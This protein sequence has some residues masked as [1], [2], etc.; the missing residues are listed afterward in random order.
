MILKSLHIE[1]FKGV[2]DKTYEFGKTTRISGM[3][4]RGKT[5]IGA[6]W[7]WLIS[8]K[9]Y[10]LVSNP[11]IR[12]DNVEDCIPTVTANVGVDEKEITLS[13]MQKRKVGKP[14]KNGVS[15]I[16]IT[17][18][19]EI[20]SVPKTERDFKAY[21]EELGFEFDKFLI[22]SHPNVFT[23][24]LSLKK[25]QDEMR[26]SLFAMASAKTDL[27]IAQ[28]NK[29]TADVAKLLESYKFE[30]IEAMNNASKKKA[31]DQLDAIPNQIIGL[32]SAKV[33]VDVAEQELA[34]A[35]LARRIAECDKKIAGADHSLDELRDKE[36]RLQLDISG[37]T[38]TMN[39]E[40]SNRRYEIDADL[41]GCEDELKHLEQTISLK[42]NQ[43]VG[44]EKAITDADAER[45]KI[46][47]KYN[48]EYAKAF[49]EAPYLFDESKWVFDENSTVCSLCGQK[50]PED[51]IEQLKADFESRKEKAKADAEEKLKAK[52]FKFDTDKKVE[53]NRLNTIGTEKK[54]LITEL[55]KKNA[56]L[57]TEIDAL[58]KQEQDAIA[59]KEE[60]SKQLSE[61][62]SEADYTQNEDYVKLKAERDKVLADIEKLESD[63]ADKVVTDLKVE[64]A[65]LQSQ[66]DEVNSIIAQA[67]NNV[68]I[69]EQIAEKRQDQRKYEQAKADA[70]KILYQLKEVSK[71]KNGLL[72]EEI[73]QHFG[74][75]RWKLFDFQKNGEYKEVCIPTVLDEETGIYKVFG[76]TTNTGR[77]I[78]AKIDI[79]NS[80]QKFF[81]MYV[82]IFLDG[83]ESINDEYVPAVDTQLILLTVTEDKQLKVEGV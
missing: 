7:Y 53:L 39:R 60:L 30:E 41:C 8:D 69:D 45:K 78:E 79:C 72:V 28:M 12:P 63:G 29:E 3:N 56:D 23:K 21:L 80:F 81:N 22:C 14:D 26:K 17:N 5:T 20:N 27:E 77:E 25:K 38:Q 55:T 19:Y 67:A 50:L 83:A 65:D 9:N 48:A 34:K 74:I 71:R 32:E 6:A 43:I 10:E 15:K 33:D 76:D 11:N 18:T 58:K 59:K 40:L 57:N 61:I 24:D 37:I 54:E 42:E 35:D 82:P 13:K 75:V 66:L 46:G 47:E 4:R 52:R 68:R 31:V 36:M 73:N 1:N 2:K 49:D 62:P 16:T 70:E 44:N 64:K 51:K